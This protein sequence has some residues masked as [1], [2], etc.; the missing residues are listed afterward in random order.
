MM[1]QM[2]LPMTNEIDVL[3]Q[4]LEEY[5]KVLRLKNMNYELLEHLQGSLFW[6]F[7]YSEKYGIP[8]PKKEEL[9]RMAKKA[10]FLLDEIYDQP[11]GNK[12]NNYREVFSHKFN[13]L[14]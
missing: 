14:V 2:I 4:T 10:D 12:D 9:M 6:L 5:Q 11:Q 1:R 8:I 13:K 7:R 3:R